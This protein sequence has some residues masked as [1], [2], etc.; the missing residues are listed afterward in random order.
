MSA[1]WLA[2]IPATTKISAQGGDIST[3]R[4]RAGPGCGGM[5][6]PC[7]LLGLPWSQPKDHSSLHAGVTSDLMLASKAWLWRDAVSMSPAWLALVPAGG[8]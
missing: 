7:L 5:R 3:G 6:C 8:P 4:W 2:L 1:A